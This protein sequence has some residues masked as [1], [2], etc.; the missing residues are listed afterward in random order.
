MARI[1]RQV[2]RVKSSSPRASRANS[3]PMMAFTS[4]P[5]QKPRPEPVMITARGARCASSAS[6]VAASSS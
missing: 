6:N 4:P 5:E 3:S 1:S 2:R